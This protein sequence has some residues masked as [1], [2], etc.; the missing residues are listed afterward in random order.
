MASITA[1]PYYDPHPPV[2]LQVGAYDYAI[3]GVLLQERHPVCFSSHTTERNYAQTEEECLAIVSFM[4]KWHYL[5][6]RQ[7]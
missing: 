2:T 3:G 4:D 1:L 5:L 7:T 6:V